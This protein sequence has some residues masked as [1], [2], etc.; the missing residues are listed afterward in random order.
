MKEDDRRFDVVFDGRYVAGHD[1]AVVQAA[2]A[3]SFGETTAT[4]VF[5]SDRAILKRK[6]APTAA[7]K[8]QRHLAELGV[9]VSLAPSLD[10]V[11]HRAQ[12]VAAKPP[13]P[14][15]KTSASIVERAAERSRARRHLRP[16]ESNTTT[17][18]AASEAPATTPTDNAS[19]PGAVAEPVAEPVAEF[20]AGPAAA[21]RAA[22]PFKRRSRSRTLLIFLALV[23]VVT[24]ITGTALY[25]L[26]SR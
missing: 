3:T 26:V 11:P 12:A 19:A 9:V 1:P 23:L 18:D 24:A 8:M 10:A 7:Q 15:K 13:P 5:A 21:P 25:M 2:F 14:K 20:V 6:I 17:P 22:V 16:V 4:R